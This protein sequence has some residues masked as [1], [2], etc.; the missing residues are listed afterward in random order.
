MRE[1]KIG[2]VFLILVVLLFVVF[3]IP[4]TNMFIDPETPEPLNT[5]IYE[6]NNNSLN[7]VFDIGNDTDFPRLNNTSL[8]DVFTSAINIDTEIHGLTLYQMLSNGDDFSSGFTTA[9]N[10]T[11]SNGE[12]NIYFSVSSTAYQSINTYSGKKYALI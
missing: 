6:L 7:D 10:V 2:F 5:P 12:L 4:V 1:N 3:M 9:G 8:N 11:V